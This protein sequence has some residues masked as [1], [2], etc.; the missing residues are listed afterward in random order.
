MT[1]PWNRSH[2]ISM[3]LEQMQ[4]YSRAEGHIITMETLSIRKEV[5][6]KQFEDVSHVLNADHA[7]L[8]ISQE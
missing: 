7:S 1:E 3:C 8:K 2:C 6:E 4:N 5:K